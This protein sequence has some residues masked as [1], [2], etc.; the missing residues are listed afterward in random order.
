MPELGQ[1]TDQQIE[2]GRIHFGMAMEGIPL[3]RG[4]STTL[5]NAVSGQVG[6]LNQVS[7]VFREGLKAHLT[8]HGVSLWR[9]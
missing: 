1:P 6:Q 9:Q 8:A 5:L 7:R 4:T 2:L 3:V